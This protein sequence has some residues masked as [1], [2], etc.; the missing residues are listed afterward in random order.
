MNTQSIESLPLRACV[1]FA[2]RCA[3]RASSVSEYGE[4][5]RSMLAFAEASAERD[6]SGIF[7]P[8]DPGLTKRTGSG[9]TVVN[10]AAYAAF[11]L[12]AGESSEAAELVNRRS[13][14]PIKRRPRQRAQDVLEATT[15]AVDATV[16]AFVR[17]GIEFDVS[18]FIRLDLERISQVAEAEGWDDNTLVSPGFFGPFWNNE[19]YRLYPHLREQDEGSAGGLRLDLEVSEGASEA[20]I[21][22][23]VKKMA[24][25]ADALHRSYG[26]HGLKVEFVEVTEDIGV[27]A[28]SPK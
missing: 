22:E 18:Y 5:V 16:V 25:E 26:G 14:M 4:G 19:A 17:A 27:P 13:R 6:L 9:E 10:W 8:N 12:N 11:M 2:A 1:A 15:R 21:I 3:R 23:L 24:V 28:E 20:E 7:P